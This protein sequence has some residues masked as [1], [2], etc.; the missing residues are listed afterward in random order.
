MRSLLSTFFLS[1]ALA[2]AGVAYAAGPTA[3]PTLPSTTP[4]TDADPGTTVE[5]SSTSPTGPSGS[6]TKPDTT[7]SYSRQCGD[8]RAQWQAASARHVG[9]RHFESAKQQAALGERSC[10]SGETAKLESGVKQLRSALRLLGEEPS[11]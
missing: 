1:S 8:L 9:S 11:I 6:Q 5:P 2:A 4:P 7:A 10:R 3:G